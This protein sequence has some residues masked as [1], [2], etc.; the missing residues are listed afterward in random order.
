MMPSSIKSQNVNNAALWAKD[1]PWNCFTPDQLGP[2]VMGFVNDHEPFFRRWAE[3]WYEN[4]QFLFGNHN[5]K[6]SRKYG[7]AVDQDF[8]RRDAG[9]AMRANTNIAR[10]VVEALASFV[11]GN[12]P[13]WIAEAMQESSIKGKSYAKIAQRILE[14]YNERILLHKE[15]KTAAIAYALF[16]QVGMEVEWNRRAG[17]LLE[18]PRYN[19]TQKPSYSTY[20][21]PNPVTGG[22]IEIPTPIVGPDGQP[23][24]ETT[25]EA[26]RD[27]KGRQIVDKVFSGD[28]GVNVLTP[29]EYR[30]QIGTYGM[31]KTRYV[32]RF[33][34]LDY[35]EFLDTYK[36]I[37]GKTPKF[38]GIR[39]VYSDPLVYQMAIRHF[40]RMQFT[41]PPSVNDGFRRTQ[42]VFK[43]SLFRY[44]VFVVEHWDHPHEDK[45]PLGRRVVVANG[46]CVAITAPDYSTNKQDGW[47]QL[48][49][50]QW[51][52]AAPN[53]ISAGP[54]NDV[55]RKNKE[56]NVKDSL[57]ATAVRRNMGSELLVKVGSG[58]DPQKKTGEP[59]NIQEVNDVMGARWLH[60]DMPIP[61]VMATLRDQ[62]KNDVYETSG[63]GDALRGQPSPGTSSGYQEKQREEREEKRLGPAR[64]EFEDMVS[65]VGEKLLSC[66]KAN[67]MHLDDSVMGFM[68]R[69]AAGEFST[70]DVVSF[71]SNSLGFGVDI[72]VKKS[73]MVIKSRA[74]KQATLQELAGGALGQRLSQD[75]KV[76]DEYLKE[77]DAD[78]FRDSSAPHRD[79]ANRENEV[80]LDMLRLGPDTEGMPKPLV[81]LEDDDLIHMAEHDECLVKNFEEF[82]NNPE[83]MQA[84]LEHKERH[85]L[86]YEEKK[87]A[88]MPGA[89]NQT[90]TMMGMAQQSALPTVQTVYL[91]TSM[92]NQ[93]QA[94][95][96]QQPAQGQ[97][98]GQPGPAGGGQQK[99]PNPKA[100]QAP[101]QPSGPGGGAG[102]IDPNAPSQNTPAAKG[103]MI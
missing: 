24:M 12:V 56:L 75:A 52:S 71:L 73:S 46:E 80:F 54:T 82:R 1:L 78:T 100:P 74:T 35:D 53:S 79:R 36:N 44:K 22:L 50:A 21:A 16:G 23:I 4:Y 34:L 28:V 69:A 64:K 20:M 14:C 10:V 6:W 89:S 5:V 97:Q 70:Q 51:M 95:M 65:G 66:L 68:K 32:Q 8:L 48:V 42:N 39:P 62:D 29:F 67:V 86:Q 19:K 81:I 40:M 84:F 59:G 63:A 27:P 76:L 7:F 9:G 94:Q 31:H 88:L 98:P 49:E 72:K 60:D 103:G 17:Q 101:R 91:D 11:Y 58:Y 85:R 30:R 61:P 47:H 99:A 93:Q 37:E 57:I 2:V 43:S 18:I 33:K 25:W 77:F 83:M 38:Q 102:K 3:V 41:A 92:R 13:E 87:G 45:W 26:V 96:Q 55:I 90:A 15:L